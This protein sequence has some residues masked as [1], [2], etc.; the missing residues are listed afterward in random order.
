MKIAKVRI[1]VHDAVMQGLGFA[2][3]PVPTR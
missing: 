1:A 3:A 2:D